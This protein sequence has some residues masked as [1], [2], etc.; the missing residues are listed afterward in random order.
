MRKID[1]WWFNVKL[2]SDKVITVINSTTAVTEFFE[3]RLMNLPASVGSLE[4]PPVRPEER[5]LIAMK[6]TLC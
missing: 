1:R 6:G 5:A 3:A 2:A 4:P